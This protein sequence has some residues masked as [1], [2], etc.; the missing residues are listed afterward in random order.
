MPADPR[1]LA[2]EAIDLDC[3]SSVFAAELFAS[4]ARTHYATLARALIEA[5]DERDEARRRFHARDAEADRLA[6]RISRAFDEV[7]AP[8]M[9]AEPHERIQMLADDR[10]H[11]R[12]E[13][14]RRADDAHAA[15]MDRLEMERGMLRACADRDKILAALPHALGKCGCVPLVQNRIN[16]FGNDL[17]PEEHEAAIEWIQGRIK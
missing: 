6:Q 4:H 16:V 9:G 13:A 5:L 15:V 8:A 10:D 1:R 3:S 11:W 7:N 14:T 2:Q 17:W 12:T